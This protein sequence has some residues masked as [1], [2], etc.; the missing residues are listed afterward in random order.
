M[1]SLEQL[2]T[3]THKINSYLK[4]QD[5]K[6]K[7]VELYLERNYQLIQQS[8]NL[9]KNIY[10]IGCG[11]DLSPLFLFQEATKFIFQDIDLNSFSFTLELLGKGTL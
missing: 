1:K 10:Y 4:D 2:K 7:I 11:K 6:F 9:W 5:N 3:G 8:N